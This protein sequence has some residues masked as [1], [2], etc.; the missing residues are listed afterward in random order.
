MYDETKL[1]SF[2]GISSNAA[3]ATLQLDGT[4]STLHREEGRQREREKERE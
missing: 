3:A 1:T 2:G 4:K